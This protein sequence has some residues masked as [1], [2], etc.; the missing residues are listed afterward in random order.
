[1]SDPS[2]PWA[3][4]PAPTRRSVLHAVGLA[5][6]TGG[7]ASVVSGCSSDGGSGTPSPSE[8]PVPGASGTSVSSPPDA[9]PSSTPSSSARAAS[10]SGSAVAV[11]DVP[12]GGGVV[13]SEADYVITQPTAGD[14]R[15]FSKFCTHKQCPLASVGGGTINCMCHGGRYSMMDGSVQAGPPPKSLPPA[16]VTVKGGWVVVT[17]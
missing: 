7:G 2:V 10:P 15:A 5:V 13:L 9:A 16:E 1:M 11:A 4:V 12:V 6:L 3:P 14:F 8:S 17:G